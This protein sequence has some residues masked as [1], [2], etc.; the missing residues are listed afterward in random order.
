MKRLAWLILLLPLLFGCSGNKDNS[1]PP[2]ELVPL[3]PS[4]DIT[5]LWQR[6]IGKG[7]KRQYIQMR[8]LVLSDRLVVVDR[9]GQLSVIDRDS[10]K[11][12]W[13]H[14]LNLKVSAGVGGDERLLLVTS[15][16]GDVV[17]ID[18]EQ[19]VEL[20]R[21]K[22][23][24]EVLS[25]PV[26]AGDKVIVRSVNGEISALARESGE[27]AWFYRRD[28]PGLTL[29]GTSTPMVVQDHI[30]V[31]LDNGR[32]V[33]LSA[34]DGHLIGEATIAIPSGRSE[35]HRLVD[36]DADSVLWANLLYSVSYQG[37]IVAMDIQRGEL[38][39][40]RD[41]SSH[42][43]MDI[44]GDS[45]FVSDER[46]HVWGLDRN[47]GATLWKLDKLNARQITAPVVM[48]E[49][50]VVGDFEGYLHWIS[51]Y[52]GRFVARVQVDKSGILSAPV[53]TDDRL[54]VLTRAGNLAAYAMRP[55]GKSEN[56][57]FE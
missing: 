19:K 8:P 29:R 57:D 4:A 37:R 9:D 47:S 7:V 3:S 53:V 16:E 6:S 40:S 23:S 48:D 34:A 44:V 56:A 2:A 38:I 49:T 10:G 43:G 15:Q 45:V 55:S 50:L 36:I 26:L 21:A 17:A 32:M 18:G 1:E 39:W 22:V 28:V 11:I 14:E 46:S 31:G 41:M 12:L 42:S 35:L 13:Q 25:P 33:V 30:Y 27:L 54:Y 5:R 24:S 20:W 51:Q 52:D